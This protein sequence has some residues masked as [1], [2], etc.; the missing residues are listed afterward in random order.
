MSPRPELLKVS[1][2]RAAYGEAEVLFGIDLEVREGEIA[3]VLGSNGA[4]K[5]TLL[6][7]ISGLLPA[8]SGIITLS[9]EDVSR[10]QVE[11]RVQRGIALVPEGRMLFSGLSVEENLRLGGYRASGSSAGERLDSVYQTFPD[12]ARRRRQL[13]G[14]L[15]GGQQQ[16]VA[17][18]RGL[19]AE[20]RLLLI[21]EFSL[22]LAPTIVET[23]LEAI[24]GLHA[25]RNLSVLIVEQDIRVGLHLA[26]RG[27]VLENGAVAMVDGAKE[28]LAN[29]RVREAYLGL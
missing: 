4:G 18:G 11:D 6:K 27:Y 23:I 25:Q 17:I 24:A 22:G 28:L 29:P 20:P 14:T 13:A 16:M 21:D 5:S 3:A 1:G 19:M 26:T 15:S 7:C 2:L 10:T 8:T 9:G 12:L